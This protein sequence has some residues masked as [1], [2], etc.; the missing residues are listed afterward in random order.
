MD[1]E[2]RSLED[3]VNQVVKLCQRLRSDNHDLR[4]Q[5][6]TALNDNKQLAEKIGVAS[7]RLEA[8]LT[9]IPDETA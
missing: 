3:K 7:T 2:L 8:L 9:Q 5:L 6:A 4:Q 1:A